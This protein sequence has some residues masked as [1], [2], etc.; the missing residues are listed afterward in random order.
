MTTTPL[1][2]EAADTGLRLTITAPAAAVT[3]GANGNAER[4]LSGLAL[5]FGQLGHTSIGPLTVP[6]GAIRIPDDLRRVKLFTEHGRTAPVG[7]ATAQASAADGLRMTFR[8]GATPAGDAALV[9]A[10]EGIRDA[11]SVELNNVVVD[12]GTVKSADLV[13]VA[14]TAV[15]AFSDARVAA[16]DHVPPGTAPASPPVTPPSAGGGAPLVQVIGGQVPPELAAA[17]RGGALTF[18][19]L[20]PEL[21][22]AIRDNDLGRVNAALADVIPINDQGLAYLGKQWLGELWTPVAQ[23]RH[24][25]NRVAKGTLTT[26]LK[27][28]GWKWENTPEVGIYAGNKTPI[29]S[30][31]VSIVPVEAP[32]VRYAGGWDIDRIYIDLGN[33]G[34]LEAFFTAATIDLGNKT[35]AAVG[36]ELSAA[37]T[38]AGYAATVF[39]AVN[40]AATTLVSAG[41]NLSYLGLA[42]D[43]FGALMNLPRSEAPW[44]LPEQGTLQI[45]A[46]DGTMSDVG[47]FAAPSLAAGEVIAGDSR[48][49]TWYEAKPF[50]IRVQA[51]NLPNGGIDIA[52]FAYSSSIVNDARG[53]VKVTVG[54]DPTP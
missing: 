46:Q 47:Y 41:A 36:T 48:A 17:Q 53:L 28:Y 21:A 23:Q 52:V 15:P 44:W 4:T 8:V 10:S 35:E 26:G 29:P 30:N 38:D 50:P 5:P 51:V 7:Y 14:L 22:A 18:S 45:K 40:L 19:A 1:S 24:F 42:P 12:Q 39:D 33:P 11:L 2:L 49:Y 3:A 20:V 54:T 34:F 16:S 6:Q 31:T 37:A 27:V 43:V 9:E 32:I 13:A 25:I